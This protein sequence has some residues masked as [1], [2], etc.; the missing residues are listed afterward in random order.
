MI[1]FQ[2]FIEENVLAALKGIQ[3]RT[4]A[5]VAHQI[6]EAVDAYLEAQ[7]RYPIPKD[8]RQLELPLDQA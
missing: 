4:G 7:N 3:D 1:R 6:R 5:S 8:P 2:M